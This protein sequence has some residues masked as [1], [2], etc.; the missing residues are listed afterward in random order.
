M[1]RRNHPDT[2][3]ARPVAADEPRRKAAID[4]SAEQEKAARKLLIDGATFETVA[5][6]FLARGQLVRREAIEN[7]FLADPKLAGERAQHM[8]KVAREIRKAIP[9]GDP[10]DLELADAVIATGLLGL[11]R[12]QAKLELK[13]ALRRRQERQ[14]GSLRA[15]I[16]RMKARNEAAINERIRAH[17]RLLNTQRQKALRQLEELESKVGRADDDKRLNEEVIQQIREIY[18]LI[19]PPIVPPIGAPQ[20]EAEPGA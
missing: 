13:D 3:E 11:H 18:G 20:I 16:T 15:Q 17:T 19:E 6:T 7:Y 14:I 9:G 2:I 4:L 10:E 5:L 12:E 8:M 1:K